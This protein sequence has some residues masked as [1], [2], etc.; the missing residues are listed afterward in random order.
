MLWFCSAEYR[1]KARVE[2]PI[3]EK[4]GELRQLSNAC[5]VLDGVTA[6]EE[7]QMTV[8]AVRPRRTAFCRDLL[9]PSSV[10]G[11]VLSCAF[12]RLASIC[13]SELILPPAAKL[14]SFRYFQAEQGRQLHGRGAAVEPCP[15]LTR[16]VYFVLNSCVGTF[17][18]MREGPK[19]RRNGQKD[20]ARA[21]ATTRARCRGGG[22][23]DDAAG[24]WGR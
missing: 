1:V 11:P 10:T 5:F 7:Y 23:P 12:R 19:P 20:R 18:R 24:R 4:T 15:A 21:S 16:T 6:T 2:R 9:L 14:A 22:A 8:S 17:D 13:R 3:V